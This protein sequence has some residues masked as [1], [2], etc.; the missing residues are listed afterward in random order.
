MNAAAHTA[1]HT[2]T[3]GNLLAS[4]TSPRGVGFTTTVDWIAGPDGSPRVSRVIAPDGN[5]TTYTYTHASTAPYRVIRTV[6]TNAR[7]FATTFDMNSGDI[8]RVTDPMANVT[9]FAYDTRHNVTRV[10]DPRGHQTTYQYNGRNKIKQIVRAVGTLNLTTALVWDS[11][12]D[13]DGLNGKD[14]LLSTTNPRGFRTE[15]TYNASHNLTRVRRAAGTPD[16]SITVYTPTTWGGIASVT[17]PR[18]HT[19]TFGYT[20]RRQLQTITPPAGGG[21]TTTYGY[22]IFDDQTTMT[23]GNGR[24]WT[25]A[26]NASRLVTSITDPLNHVVRHDFDANGNHTRTTDARNYATTFEYDNRNRLTVI[27]DPMNGLTRYG[28]D[29]V[30][31]LARITNARNYATTFDYDGANR[32]TRVTDAL[33]QVTTYGYDAASNRTSMVER[34][35]NTHT[36]TYD[37]VNR[38]TKVEAGTLSVTH[39]YDPN[40]NRITLIDGGGTTTFAFDS[41]DRFTRRTTPDNRNVLHV[42]DANGNRTR[43]TYPDGSTALTF[44]YDPGN[45]LAQISQGTLTWTFSY[46]LAGN[47]MSVQQPNGTRMEYTYQTNNWLQSITHK[48][49]DASP[50][51]FFN[52]GYDA[53]GNRTSQTDDSGTTTFTYDPLNRVTG[54]TYPG[55][56]GNWSWTYDPVGNRATQTAP[57]GTTTYTYD[58]NNRLSQAGTVTYDYDP[59]G[60]LLSTSASRT[61]T[62][63]PFN[64]LKNASGSGG[65]VTYTY[66]GDGLKVRRTGPDGSTVY[67]YDGIRP[68]WEADG[69]GA[70]KAQL[71]RDIF[72]NLLSRR[73]VSGI[74]RYFAY[75]GLGGLTAVTDEAGSHLASL[76]YDAWGTP[77]ATSGTWTAGNYRFAGAE[78]DSATG[79]YHMG[80]RFY[81]P[82]LG[83]WLS[84]D[85]VQNRLFDPR[86]LNFYAY[87]AN[88]P[89]RYTDPTGMMP[90]EGDGGSGPS[91][92][93]WTET[94]L[95]WFRELGPVAALDLVRQAWQARNAVIDALA[96]VQYGDANIAGSF[97][98]GGMGGIIYAADGQVYAYAG[99]TV[100]FGF[101]F[102]YTM[103]AQTVTTG[104]NIAVSGTVPGGLAFQIGT[105]LGCGA[106]CTYLEIGVS[107][108][109]PSAIL[110]LF[111]VW[112]IPKGR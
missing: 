45:R 4:V 75:D 77:R 59:N 48:R 42:Y 112:A 99:V 100:G 96:S 54:A 102:A 93:T 29:A 34:R 25:T 56:Y 57:S 17:N 3:T 67:Y 15:Y 58:A 65:D 41:L 12:E 84:E 46:D 26:Y 111:K 101:G 81:E 23:N 40:G 20:A 16:E 10:T 76:F 85:S 2:Y 73:E 72:G 50:F 64:R 6:V 43:L 53:N 47:R 108:P 62:W 86:S 5:A 52:Y 39:G 109:A 106:N 63:D 7:G 44:G 49:P 30:N 105:A 19:T 60:N 13:L 32:L 35:G 66:D 55:A 87:V 78:L 88:N 94:V 104:W 27:T 68:I 1:T 103:S 98:V 79:L 110:A 37:Q 8:E 69:T 36:Y 97:I 89:V 61:F 11:N 21:G 51:Q 28:Y 9:Q 71:D 18:G 70:L 24:R 74:R 91:T 80:A 82:L 92:R 90:T 38:L 33:N 107:T 14:N 22:D 83:R 31:N 95:E